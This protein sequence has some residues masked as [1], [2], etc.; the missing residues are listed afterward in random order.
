MRLAVGV[1]LALAVCGVLGKVKT[2]P[3]GLTAQVAN[4]Q[5]LHRADF[6][7]RHKRD[8]FG[9]VLATTLRFQSH[10]R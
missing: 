1:V 3:A 5:Q 9:G 7:V 10:G 6:D 4:I 8:L 2:L